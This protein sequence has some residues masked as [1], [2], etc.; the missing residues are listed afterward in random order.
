MSTKKTDANGD[1]ITSTSSVT[2]GEQVYIGVTT[3]DTA[4]GT[5]FYLSDCTATN[6]EDEFKPDGSGGTLANS[7][8]KS[9]QLVKGGCMF[10]LSDQLTADIAPAMSGQSL[11]FNQF[12]FADS[13]QSKLTFVFSSRKQNNN[14][15]RYPFPCVQSNM[16]Y[17]PRYSTYRCYLCH[18]TGRYCRSSRCGRGPHR[19]PSSSSTSSNSSSSSRHRAHR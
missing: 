11:V 7:A 10:K 12:A 14:I 2:L 16:R 1:D 3:T 8:Y 5:S 4:I 9:L 17:C 6:G 13:S 15:L 19:E 18:K